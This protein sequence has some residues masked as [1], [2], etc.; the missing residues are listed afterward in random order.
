MQGKHATGKGD[1]LRGRFVVIE[2]IDG[3]GK[4]LQTQRLHQHVT[5]RGIECIA[6][7]EPGGSRLGE[8]IRAWLLQH[9]TDALTEAFLFNAAR[10]EH[11]QRLIAPALAR[12]TWVV[13][14]RFALSGF[15]Y[16]GAGGADLSSLEDLHRIALHRIACDSLDEGRVQ[17]KVDLGFLLDLP[18]SDAQARMSKKGGAADPFERRGRAFFK[19]VRALFLERAEQEEDTWHII[20][21][22]AS[23]EEV[24]KQICNTLDQHFFTTEND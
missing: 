20:D 22:R 2:G 17:I 23:S 3:A 11:A 21:A 16:Q 24:T 5:Q 9:E 8:N 12:G 15:A 13:C 1:G 18:P 7:F 14:D 6:T 4:S 10:R 19:H